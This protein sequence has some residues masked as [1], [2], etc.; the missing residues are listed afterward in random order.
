MNGMCRGWNSSFERRAVLM[1]IREWKLSSLRHPV[2]SRRSSASRGSP[3]SGSAATTAAVHI[4]NRVIHYRVE[5]RIAGLEMDVDRRPHDPGAASRM[6]ETLRSASA[7]RRFGA[8]TSVDVLG[9][10]IG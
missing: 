9:L 7:R 2:L 3:S 8:E 4:G 6:A 1:V 5:Q 10:L